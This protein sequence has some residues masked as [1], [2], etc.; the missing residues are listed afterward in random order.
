MQDPEGSEEGRD[1]TQKQVDDGHKGIIFNIQRFCVN[2]G[3]GI[4]T[5]VFLKGC[6]LKCLWC[7]N[8]ES[9]TLCSQVIFNVERCI[10]LF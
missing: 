9:Q 6:S 5:L 2:D 3:P 1:K 7:F 4:R 8:P 10:D